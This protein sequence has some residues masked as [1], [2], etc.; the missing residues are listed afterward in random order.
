VQRC[1]TKGKKL[2]LEA[3]RYSYF[4]E[5]TELTFLSPLYDSEA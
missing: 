4:V 3:S 2:R 5:L 1:Y